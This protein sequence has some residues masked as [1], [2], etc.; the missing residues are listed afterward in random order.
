[1]ELYNPEEQ[2]LNSFWNSFQQLFLDLYGSPIATIAAIQGHALAAGAMLAMACDYRIMSEPDTKFYPTIGLNE[3]KF[4][5]VAPSWMGQLLI[6]TIGFRHAEQALSLG[7]T[8]SPTEA[9]HIGLIDRVVPADN[10]LNVSQAQAQEWS[11]MP[12]RARAM[13]KQLTRKTLIE[14]F[15]QSR[16]DDAQFFKKYILTDA[17][18]RGL[19]QYLD[20]LKKKK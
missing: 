6:Q 1:M 12:P 8:F 3:T 17:V 15:H 13:T 7:T 10:I 5:I 20:A 16:D 19:A 11:K 14:S 4:G 9:L 2:R 18:Q